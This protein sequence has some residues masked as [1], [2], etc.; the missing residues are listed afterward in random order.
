MKILIPD[1]ADIDP[2][3]FAGHEVICY[4]AGAPV[5][6]VHAD[7]EVLVVWGT[8]L[9]VLQETAGRLQRVRLVQ[10]L[11]AGPDEVVAAGFRDEAVICSGSGLHNQPVAE[12]A[13]ALMPSLV[14]RLPETAR[15]QHQR[16]WDDD[17]GGVQPLHPEDRLTTLLGARVLIWGFGAIGQRLAELCTVLGA[18]VTG[19]ARTAGQRGGY[20]V[21]TPERLPD[22]LPTTDV[23]V[24]I[25]PHVPETEYALDRR[26]LEALPQ[27]AFVVNVGRGRTVDEDVLVDALR[28]GSIAGAAIDVAVQEPLPAESDLRSAPHLVITPHMAG[29]RPVGAGDLLL[30]NV[31]ALT[32]GR[33]LIN[34]VIRRRS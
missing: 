31:A 33:E 8:P 10:A 4:R 34:R 32:E 6:Q 27:R 7:A 29:G 28:S 18:R 5:P 1:T 2:G 23:L 19:V 14:R 17:L 11:A 25:L 13:L 20:P 26:I 24:L 22:C 3:R 15:R 21:I 9:G 12:H 30:Q 16:C